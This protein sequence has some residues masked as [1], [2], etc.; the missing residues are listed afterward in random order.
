MIATDR[1]S[2]P[3]RRRRALHG[4]HLRRAALAKPPYEEVYLNAYATVA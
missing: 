1:K 3:S 2:L 4:Q